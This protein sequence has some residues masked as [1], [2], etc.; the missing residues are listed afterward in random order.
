[1]KCGMPIVYRTTNT[2][3]DRFYIGF[4]GKDNHDYLGSGIALNDAIKKYGRDKFERTTIFEGTEEECLE[5]EEFIVDEEFVLSESNY[6]LTVG[7]G[8]PPVCHGNQHALGNTYS[9]KESSKKAIAEWQA[10]RKKK[11]ESVTKMKANRKGKGT[12]KNNAMANPEHRAKVSASKVGRKRVYQP[13]GSFKYLFP[14][15]I[16]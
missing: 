9:H 12:G 2:V 13:D 14:E 11:P 3:T 4:H 10:G 7:G 5:L 16:N 15:E 6:N 1:M 8:K